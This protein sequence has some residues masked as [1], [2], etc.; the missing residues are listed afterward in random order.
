MN[1]LLVAFAL[2]VE[3]GGE[4]GARTAP[5]LA[6]DVTSEQ[7]ERLPLVSPVALLEQARAGYLA[8]AL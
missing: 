6:A 4:L 1:R 5:D 2:I 3:S 7:A 8:G